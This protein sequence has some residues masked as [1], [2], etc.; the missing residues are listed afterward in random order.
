M[1]DRGAARCAG[2]RAQTIHG[3]AGRLD[4]QGSNF[5]GADRREQ[6][7]DF[8]RPVFT[9]RCRHRAPGREAS[10]LERK[11]DRVTRGGSPHCPRRPQRIHYS[12]VPP[13]LRQSNCRRPTP[14]RIHIRVRLHELSHHLRPPQLRRLLKRRDPGISHGIRVRPRLQEKPIIPTD[15]VC[16]A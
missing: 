8:V 2:M 13:R 15:P 14:A 4:E 7:V 10:K 5:A 1:N 6:H 3:G 12:P 16:A 11:R 9:V